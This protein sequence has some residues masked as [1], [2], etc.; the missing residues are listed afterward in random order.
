M[1][2]MAGLR[3]VEDLEN[4]RP[5]KS[6]RFRAVAENPV[7]AAEWF[8]RVIIIAFKSLLGIDPDTGV[9]SDDG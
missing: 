8:H 6:D 5:S 7:A 9:C 4:N 3:F 1:N 2:G